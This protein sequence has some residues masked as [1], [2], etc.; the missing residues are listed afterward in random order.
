MSVL[1]EGNELRRA[2]KLALNLLTYE[3]WLCRWKP[4][5]MGRLIELA[6]QV[7]DTAQFEHLI[8]ELDTMLTQCGIDKSESEAVIILCNTNAWPGPG[9]V[10]Y[11]QRAESG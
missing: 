9:G 6:R 5:M 7:V 8:A 4:G 2:V 1:E 11:G 10:R 3:P